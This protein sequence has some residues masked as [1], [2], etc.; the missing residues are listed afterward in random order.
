MEY[1]Q[2]ASISIAITPTSASNVVGQYHE[3]GGSDFGAAL[4][5]HSGR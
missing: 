3:I 4:V 5:F 2:E 1:F